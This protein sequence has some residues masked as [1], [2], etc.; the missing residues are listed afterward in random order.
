M[1]H[2]TSS[3]C[4]IRRYFQN[5]VFRCL[6]TFVRTE[7]IF[8]TVSILTYFLIANLTTSSKKLSKKQYKICSVQNQ[9][10]LRMFIVS[11]GQNW[12]KIALTFLTHIISGIGGVL[13]VGLD[14]IE[15]NSQEWKPFSFATN[16]KKYLQGFI[17][18]CPE[19]FCIGKNSLNFQQEFQVRFPGTLFSKMVES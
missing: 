7:I 4:V 17:H 18:L 15:T 5:S 12:N 3:L 13:V 19:G 16:F 1:E 10:V 2:K 14:F 8:Q 11:Y 6:Q 9:N